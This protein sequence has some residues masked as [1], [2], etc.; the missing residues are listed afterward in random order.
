M[1][2]I[3]ELIGKELICLESAAVVG[4]VGNII[5]D[6]RLR[7]AKYLQ[8]L[9]GDDTEPEVQY[10]EFRHVKSLESDACIVNKVSSLLFQWSLGYT[11]AANPMNCACF[12]SG[13]KHLGYV[14]DIFLEGRNVA[15]LLVNETLFTPLQLLSYSDRLLIL[16]DTGKPI[17]LTKSNPKIPKDG[18]GIKATV[19]KTVTRE[20]PANRELS[21][22]DASRAA[23]LSVQKPSKAGVGL[24]ARIPPESTEVSRSPQ[25][26]P[27]PSPAYVFLLGKKLSR[28]ILAGDGTVLLEEASVIDEDAVQT[29]RR[30]EKLVHL[31]L[32]A[33]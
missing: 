20:E 33:D 31:A 6:S 18:G 10:A 4:T 27:S 30:H 19:H 22:P 29:A 2:K 15:S 32:Y 26:A 9:N 1:I 25:K 5:F 14:R 24:P 16:N 8:I 11:G 23:Q 13:G 7:T 21:A 3:S 12:N 17:K 28:P